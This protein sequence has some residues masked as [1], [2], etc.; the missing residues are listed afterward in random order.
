MITII[1]TIIMIMTI[2]MTIIINIINDN[3]K[4]LEAGWFVFLFLG[5]L[6]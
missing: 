3:L 4:K 5:C 1:N 2:N 6:E